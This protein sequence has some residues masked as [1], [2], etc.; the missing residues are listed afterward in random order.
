MK[1][2]FPHKC[3]YFY[4]LIFPICGAKEKNIFDLFAEKNKY[5]EIQS[6]IKI[7]EK[8]IDTDATSKKSLKDF[9]KFGE[10][11]SGNVT[12]NDSNVDS[13]SIWTSN[14]H[15]SPKDARVLFDRIFDAVKSKMG[16]GHIVE[17]IPNHEDASDVQMD[18]Y[19]WK[20]DEDIVVLM[21]TEYPTRAGIYL[22]RKSQSKWLA[23][24]GADSGKF[25]TGIMEIIN[26][27]SISNSPEKNDLPKSV[28][29]ENRENKTSPS[30]SKKSD[31]DTS[32]NKHSL[33]NKNL[34]TWA[35]FSSLLFLIL[36]LVIINLRKKK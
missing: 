30:S 33:G 36:C 10:D 35:F 5:N 21:I 22:T 13:V 34:I 12:V 18:A 32:N 23:N 8:S 14:H 31:L 20:D 24:M 1:H 3:I 29:I 26:Q 19:I 9:E 25:W 16:T 28:P 11:F 2:Y 6:I 4:L 27:K 7:S 17:N 15:I